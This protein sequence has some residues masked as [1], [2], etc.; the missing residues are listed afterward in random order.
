MSQSERPKSIAV[1]GS[2]LGGLSAA[3]RLAHAGFSVE[4][5]ETSDAVGGKAG[6]EEYSGYRFDTG[7]SLVTMKEV[8][9]EL[10]SS[11]GRRIEDYLSFSRLDPICNYWFSDGTDLIAHAEPQRFAVE[12]EAKTGESAARVLK[13]L[14]YSK[15]IWD[16]TK[17]VFLH[18]S[19]HDLRT[20]VSRVFFR[21]LFRVGKIDA[22]RSMH[23]AQSSF[24][25]DPRVIQLFNR[26]ATYNGSNP[27]S[28][29]ATLN[30]IPYVEYVLGTYSV[31][32]GIVAI[33]QA[34]ERL[35][36]E[37]GVRFHTGSKVDRLI[38]SN[39]RRVTGL[40]TNGN[41]LFFD[42]TV[43]NCDVTTAY[44]DLLH[45][46]KDPDYLSYLKAEPS[47]SGLVLYWGMKSPWPELSVNN[48]FFGD[49]YRAEFDAVFTSRT[50]AP[51]PTFYINI[52]SKLNPEDAPS[53]GEN[54]FILV[55]APYEDQQNW[56]AELDKV[57]T[58]IAAAIKTK[59]GRDPL[60]DLVCERVM[61]PADIW[62]KTGS[63]RGSLYGIS[64]NSRGA[65]FRRHPNKSRRYKGLF[66]CGGSVHPGGGMP[67][68]LL[69]GKI[70]SDLVKRSI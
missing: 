49:D 34:L 40:V 69:S 20:F 27:Y 38:V 58:W 26:Y 4:I 1:V 46:E 32:G 7:P 10:F 54:W 61:T 63:H 57:R 48:I 39:H 3:I 11:S 47:S 28:A 24:F 44:R 55:N 53:G 67:L 5:F 19:L 15:R 51:Q 37:L 14:D 12:V 25:S 16:I 41:E 62:R 64:S 66:F 22:F 13:F 29:P 21:S 60:A 31:R 56:V 9:E 6:S 8:F 45:D 43:L 33:P 18:R 42:A 50:L 36:R 70:C 65:A 68:V 30:I 59:L 52:S 2:G 35:A 17:D 23:D